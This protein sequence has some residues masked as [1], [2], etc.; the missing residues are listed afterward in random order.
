MVF[1]HVCQSIIRR[2]IVGFLDSVQS[3]YNRWDLV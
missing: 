2:Q 1:V 3:A